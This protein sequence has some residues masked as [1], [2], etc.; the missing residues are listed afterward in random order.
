MV[1]HSFEKDKV[2]TKKFG[3]AEILNFMVGQEDHNEV[4]SQFFLIFLIDWLVFSNANIIYE[5]Q[6]ALPKNQLPTVN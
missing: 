3:G 6:Q 5:G 1:R 2:K 4:S